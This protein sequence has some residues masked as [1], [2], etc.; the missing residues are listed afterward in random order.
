MEPRG[1]VVW[2]EFHAALGMSPTDYDFQVFRI[3]SKISE[4]VFPLTIDLDNP[5]FH[6]GLERLRRI[7][8]ASAAAQRQGGTAGRIKRLGLALAGAAAFAR[9][10]FI[11]TKPNAPPQ[12]VR[13]APAW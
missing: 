13:L 11:P 8:E 12:H 1:P 7:A 5:A 9:L 10:Y 4:Q 2:P 3:T 6:A